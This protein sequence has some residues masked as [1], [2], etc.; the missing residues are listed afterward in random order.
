MT[1]ADEL[2]RNVT[3][4]MFEAYEEGV[5]DGASWNPSAEERRE[6]FEYWLTKHYSSADAFLAAWEQVRP[7]HE[8]PTDKP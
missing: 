5:R 4:L 2:I 1:N 3:A 7:T 8:L 6:S